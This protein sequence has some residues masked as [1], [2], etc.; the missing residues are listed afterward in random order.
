MYIVHVRVAPNVRFL[1]FC[2]KSMTPRMLTSQEGLL[3]HR[4]R[5][6]DDRKGRVLS[7]VGMLVAEIGRT[8]VPTDSMN[9]L[10]K[11]ISIIDHV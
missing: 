8:V 1:P 5:C 6:P 7:Q 11:A 4:R 10:W 3:N 9:K 2:S